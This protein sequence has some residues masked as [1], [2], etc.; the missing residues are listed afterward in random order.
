[1]LK[2]KWN[3]NETEKSEERHRKIDGSSGL[4]LNRYFLISCRLL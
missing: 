1:M 4:E 3:C 2:K